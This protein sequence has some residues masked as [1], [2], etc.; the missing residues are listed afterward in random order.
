LDR[1][2]HQLATDGALDAGGVAWARAHR[3]EHGGEFDSALLELDLVSEPTLLRALGAAFGMAAATPADLVNMDSEVSKRLPQSF[4]RSF[5]LCPVRFAEKRLVALVQ[6][7]L[8]AEWVQEL[9]DLFNL[10]LEQRV[11]PSH[12]L[13]LGRTRVYG[14]VA[15]P[16]TQEL[17]A[18]L[19]RRRNAPDVSH[20]VELLAQAT[21]LPDAVRVVLDF[22]AHL[23][24]G[25]C[26]LV[27]RKSG[28]EVI[29]NGPRRPIAPPE[30]DSS[31]TPALRHGGY[32]LGAI[33]G[34]PADR[35][36]FAALDRPVPR[37]AFVAPVPAGSRAMLCVDNGF[38]GIAVQWVAE[39]T[40][41]VARVGR[42]G[43]AWAEPWQDLAPALAQAPKP[44]EAEAAPGEPPVEVAPTAAPAP[45]TKDLVELGDRERAAIDRLRLAAAQAQ[46]SLDELVDELL[47]KHRPDPN[48]S[49]SAMVAE[50]K[51]LFERLATDIP[52]QLARGMESAFRDM[53]PR[54][55]SAPVRAEAAQSTVGVDLVV[56]PAA[57]REVASYQSRRG[58]SPRVKL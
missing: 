49:A 37:W 41:L 34:N 21:T 53:V 1:L 13:E 14:S 6:G 17:E 27:P 9:R 5:Q 15:D 38:R 24:E 16:R 51:G 10:E 55:G 30:P 4:S 12:Y 44:S 35:L 58:K 46:M 50:V 52:A 29:G 18:R 8:P 40:L 20:V 33:A 56:K 7:P 47:S 54:I 2:L 26:F 36:F 25:C 19:V 32:F 42:W 43:R 23:V 11:A 57:P 39:L 3:I 28:L 45:A 22:A 31:L 48:L